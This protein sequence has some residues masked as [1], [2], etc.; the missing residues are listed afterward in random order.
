MPQERSTTA[1]QLAKPVLR[2]QLLDDMGSPEH[3]KHFGAGEM[4][5]TN[6]RKRSGSQSLRLTSPTKG[7][8]PPAVQGRPF[9]ESGIRRECANADWSAFNRVSIWVYP[10]LPGFKVI[11]L[12]LKLRSEGT[13]GRSYTDG[14]LHFVLLKNGQWN[15]VTWEI[16]H[17]DRA[18]V[19]AVEFIYRLQGNEPDATDKVCF[20]F[21]QL[22][23]QAVEPEYYEGWKPATNQIAYSH[24]GY[25]PEAAKIALAST[26]EKGFELVEARTLKREWNGPAQTVPTRDGT[27]Q[28]LDFTAFKRPGEYILKLGG[29]E[30]R[31]FQIA[32]DCWREPL[33][34][35]L[36]FFFRERCGFSVPGI[37]DV[38]HQDWTVEHGGRKLP[39]NGG[40][41]DAGDLSQGL[42]NS[43]E[44]VWSMLRL[45]A[46][47][48]EKPTLQGRGRA[49]LVLSLNDSELARRFRDEAKWGAQ[50]LL[51]TR[52]EDGFRVTWATMD[53][54]TDGKPGT[55]DDV[56]VRAGDSPFENFIAATAEALAARTYSKAEPEFAG[57]CQAAASYDF[58]YALGKTRRAGTELLGAA[59]QAAIELY[60]LTG[61][62]EYRSNA[63]AFADLLV[64]CQE[65]NTPGWEKPLAGFFYASTERSRILHYNHRSHE[66]GP[67]IAL[68]EACETFP[69]VPQ[70]KAWRAAVQAYGKYVIEGS[71]MASPYQMIPAG[72]YRIAEVQ[73]QSQR[74]Q[75]EK[76]IRLADGVYLRC[77]PTWGDFRGNLGVLLSQAAAAAAAGRLLDSDPLRQLAQRQLEWTLGANPFCQSL[78]Y[79]V[80]HDF[81]PQYTAMSGD[82]TGSLP[83]GIQSRLDADIPYWPPSNCYN[84]AEIWVHPVSRFF[85]TIAELSR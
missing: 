10:D 31:P 9:G 14:G 79:G 69:R 6:E 8:R 43:S 5:F 7:E 26:S 15:Q 71:A 20:Y 63:I 1:R 78:M 33:V 32:N 25:L 49:A 24:V 27:V 76:G 51:K 50:W 39:I 34:A 3:W 52:F 68:A 74:R 45:A 66:Q 35:G 30:S 18:R 53:F 13:E 12:L 64:Q 85:L 73:D 4:T 54:W 41:H 38:C 16:A 28:L 58:A 29:I 80:G 60:R 70:A 46:K 72:I 77:F 65:T 17:L 57:K 11:S 36:N 56:I 23:L 75:I 42:V 40:W 55:V 19:A 22:E 37:H 84:Y 44:T 61:Q 47:L 2:N 59:T 62:A 48:E 82:I 81:A 67:V 83:V 21:D